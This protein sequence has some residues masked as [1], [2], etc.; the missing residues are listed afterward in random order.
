MA[1]VS[2]V[3]R[4]DKINKKNEAPIHFRIIKDRKINY[5]SSGIIIPE[6]NWD[7]KNNRIKAK[8][9]NSAR[10]NSF[11]SNKFSELQDQVY[12]HETINKSLT[13]RGLRDKIY[14]RKPSDFFPFAD[15]VCEIY[16]KDGKIGTYDKNVSI[17]AKMKKYTEGRSISFQD[18][19][20]EFLG[21]YE[22][23]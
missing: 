8:H 20:P 14:G 5:I 18:I 17:I 15:E 10:L 6:E 16:L 1:S 11:L 13:S 9:T 4:R 3:F 12:E 19:T 22:T 7:V 23:F 21:K 2:I